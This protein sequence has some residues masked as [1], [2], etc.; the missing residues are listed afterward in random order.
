MF[1]KLFYLLSTWIGLVVIYV[2]LSV[3]NFL[4]L[5]ENVIFLC[6]ADYVSSKPLGYDLKLLSYCCL[7]TH[8]LHQSK[9]VKIFLPLAT[10][11]G[12]HSSI[13]IR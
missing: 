12:S 13:C 5:L 3:G 11:T 1:P 7:L 9:R 4:R 8:I 6:V 10:P 2:Q